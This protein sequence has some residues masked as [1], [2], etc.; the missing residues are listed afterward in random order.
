MAE[1]CQKYDK[2]DESEPR[3]NRHKEDQPKV[4]ALLVRGHMTIEKASTSD[5]FRT[6]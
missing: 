2:K 4:T 3:K 6:S 1:P 5:G